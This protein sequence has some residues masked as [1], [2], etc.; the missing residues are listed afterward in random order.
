MVAMSMQYTRRWV[1]SAACR[2]PLSALPLLVFGGCSSTWGRTAILLEVWADPDVRAQVRCLEV[3]LQGGVEG[4]WERPRI[5]RERMEPESDWPLRGWLEP[6][7][8]EA[9]RRFRVSVRGYGAN[10]CDQSG[11]DAIVVSRAESGWIPGQ[12]RVLTLWLRKTCLG[13]SCSTEEETCRDGVCTAVRPLDPEALPPVRGARDGGISEASMDAAADATTDAGSS[14]PACVTEGPSAVLQYVSAGWGHSCAVGRGSE[15]P[16]WCWGKNDSGQLGTG[17]RM[18]RSVPTRVPMPTASTHKVVASRE[19][20]C[21]VDTAGSLFCWGKNDSGQLGTGDRMPRE[22]PAL[23]EGLSSV[24]DVAAGVNHSCAVDA[25]GSLFCWGSN[26]YGQL[27]IGG[28]YND[29]RNCPAEVWLLG[30]GVQILDAGP[31]HTC[32]VDAAGSL[33]C[34]GRNDSGQLGTGDT[35]NRNEPTEV[36]LP[37]EGGVGIQ[38]L[39]LGEGHSCALDTRGRVWCWGGRAFVGVEPPDE[40]TG[41]SPPVQVDG[42]TS[43]VV[44]IDS[45]SHHTCAKDEMGRFF[46]WGQASP[47]RLGYVPYTAPP[48]QTPWEWQIGGRAPN[49]RLFSVGW[50]H[51]LLVGEDGR[52]R[53]HRWNQYGQIGTGDTNEKATPALVRVLCETGADGLDGGMSDGS[54]GEGGASTCGS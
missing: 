40:A 34:W 27:G 10:D 33:F 15:G 30:S 13:V 45:Q 44:A 21:A 8:G 39:A 31:F 18:N 51:T 35:M 49:P 37:L 32:A 54:D 38:Q 12:A 17:D 41:P 2:W 23:V 52:L 50:L 36:A 24:R 11:A 43:R 3:S 6:R 5:R 53:G 26:Y 25:A 19:H 48:Q 16:V 46:C 1:A 22:R 20:T 9:A 47:S 4:S 28:A 42:L 29:H 7:G 14:E